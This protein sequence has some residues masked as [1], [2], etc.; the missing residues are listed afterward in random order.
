MKR[1]QV[2]NNN[3]DIVNRQIFVN[4]CDIDCGLRDKWSIELATLTITIN[5]NP[6]QFNTKI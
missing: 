4:D 3:N 2:H 6:R 1:Y 5:H